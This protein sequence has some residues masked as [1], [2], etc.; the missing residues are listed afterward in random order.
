MIRAVG[1]L[2][3]RD[4]KDFL[5]M[6]RTVVDPANRIL[7]DHRH[8]NYEIAMVVRG[9]GLYDT[10]NGVFPISPGDV[11]VFSSNEPHW[12]LEIHEAGLE[13][14]NLHFNN[15]LFQSGCSIA[16]LYPNLFFSHSKSFLT[17]IPADSA[18]P[19]CGLLHQI[20]QELEWGHPESRECITSYLNL[21]YVRLLRE[22]N[23]YTPQEGTHNAVGRIKGSLQFIDEHFSEEISLEQIAAASGLSPN[24]FT[25]LFKECFHVKL[26]DHV[27]SK[28]IDAAKK[29]LS[30]GKDLTVLEIALACGFHNTANFNR[31]FLRFT[32]LTPSQF[33]SGV[34]IH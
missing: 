4:G 32:G 1:E 21:I 7:Q 28:R 5:K 24:Y 16:R 22:H 14:M 23:Y 33:R 29:L 11:F 26:W 8:G 10:V 20:R 30:S 15:E 19:I 13:I 12:I 3:Q 6:W 31:A 9:S 17:R 2:R 34:P 25:S 27:L 18:A